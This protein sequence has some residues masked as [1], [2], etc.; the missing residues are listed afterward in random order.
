MDIKPGN[1]LPIY[2]IPVG[3]LIHN[4]E[5]KR[6]GGGKLVRSA[7]CYATITG[8]KENYVTVKLPSGEVRLINN[9]C[10]ATVGQLS[11]TDNRNIVLGKAGAKDGKDAG[12]RLEVQ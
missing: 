12:Q 5:L 8:R 1:T 3:T 10:K 7:G 4:I 9:F 11:N 6:D 2:L